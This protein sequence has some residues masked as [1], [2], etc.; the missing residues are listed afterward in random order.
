MTKIYWYPRGKWSGDDLF[1]KSGTGLV[2]H[3]SSPTGFWCW[4]DTIG[5]VNIDIKI[6]LLQHNATYLNYLNWHHSEDPSQYGPVTVSHF[7]GP[8]HHRRRCESATQHSW[9]WTNVKHHHRISQSYCTM[10]YQDI[11]TASINTSASERT[12]SIITVSVN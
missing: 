6:E 12:C 11:I 5:V 2:C 10:T 1:L 7:A 4:E 8:C 3:I 9:Q